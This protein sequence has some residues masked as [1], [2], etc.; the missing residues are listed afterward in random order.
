ME[1]GGKQG[2]ENFCLTHFLQQ[3]FIALKSAFSKYFANFFVRNYKNV[4]WIGKKKTDTDPIILFKVFPFSRK[5]GIIGSRLIDQWSNNNK[6]FVTVWW[7]WITSILKM[8]ISWSVPNNME[9]N[10]GCG[11]RVFIYTKVVIQ[12]FRTLFYVHTSLRIG[13]IWIFFF[14][15]PSDYTF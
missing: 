8:M 15:W 11:R 10:R 1:N 7:V 5:L 2:A 6:K 14:R 13:K 9:E 12:I 4:S 3:K